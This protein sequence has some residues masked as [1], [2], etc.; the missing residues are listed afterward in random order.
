MHG[1]ELTNDEIRDAEELFEL[2]DQND[3]EEIEPVV[4]KPC[5]SI[6]VLEI[7]NGWMEEWNETSEICTEE[8]NLVAF[9]VLADGRVATIENHYRVLVYDPK[10]GEQVGKYRF[11][12]YNGYAT[13]VFFKGDRLY[14]AVSPEG[15]CQYTALQV[16]PGSDDEHQVRIGDDINCLAATGAGDIVVS[17]NGSDGSLED[18]EEEGEAPPLI[19]IFCADGDRKDIGC[20]YDEDTE[21]PSE[22]YVIDVTLDRQERIWAMLDDEETAVM[23]DKD[24][25][26]T[27]YSLPISGVSA[28]AVPDDC[29]CL[30]ASSQD[31][32]EEGCYW[33]FRIPMTEDDEEDEE[34][35]ICAVQ[36]P[37]GNAVF[38]DGS[39]FLKNIMAALIDGVIYVINL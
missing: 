22:D 37:E 24:G 5:M 7:V 23:Y 2:D 10:S 29:S 11:K 8:W 27:V 25:S 34:P 32:E 39:S 15:E 6:D 36:T 35:E 1:K 9:P 12:I 33:L 26:L 13:T 21:E 4:L 30:Y 16:W 38:T 14:A 3:E 18:A 19:S 17:Y 31:E 20:F 28:L